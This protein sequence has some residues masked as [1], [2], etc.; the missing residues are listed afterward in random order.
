MAKLWREFSSAE[1]GPDAFEMEEDDKTLILD[2]CSNAGQMVDNVAHMTGVL[3][4]I[5]ED[6]LVD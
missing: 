1:D 4:S 5:I 6:F 2:A 3:E